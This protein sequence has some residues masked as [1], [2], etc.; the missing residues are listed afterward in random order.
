MTIDEKIEK[1]I[2]PLVEMYSKIESDLLCE[3]ASHFLIGEEFENADYYRIKKLEEMGA[4]NQNTIKYLSKITGA[5]EDKIRGCLQDIGIATIDTPE[6]S[7]LY[8]N[9]TINVDPKKLL[10]SMPIQAIID[11][12]YNEISNHFIELSS[13]IKNATR[14]AYLKVVEESYLKV[15]M[16]THSYDEAIRKAIDDLSNDGISVMK[17][18]TKDEDGNVIG[19]RSYD[20]EGVVRRDA[21]TAARQLSGNLNNQL[22]E[23]TQ[24][25]YVK[26][27]EHLD[28]RDTHF[29]WQGTIVKTEDWKSIADYGDIAGIYGINCRHYVEPYFGDNKG[30][31]EKK[32]TQEEC[33]KAYLLS[34]KQ[35]YLERGVRSW[36]RKAKMF[37]ASNDIYSYKKAVLKT[38][39]WQNKLDN[40]NDYA[41]TRRD[42]SREYV[43][44]YKDAT[45]NIIPPK[46]VVDK[47]EKINIKA[48]DSL[49]KI[50]TNL[51][52]RN[53]NQ[54]KKLTD[55]YKLKDYYKSQ[56]AIYL[57][58]DTS[59][60]IGAIGYNEEMTELS[61][62]SSYQY[63]YDKDYLTN[64]VKEH[65]ETGYYMPCKE[66]NYDIYAMTHE[67]GHTLEMKIFKDKYPKG[68]NMKYYHFCSNVKNDIINIALEKNPNL[69]LRIA[70]SNYGHDIKTQEFFAEAFANMELGKPNEIGKAMK[71]YLKREGI[72]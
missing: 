63:F 62:N 64:K 35:R 52:Q 32:Y 59:G 46:S 6:L 61:I 20:I 7:K 65:V 26:Y 68:N 10:N 31:E 23:E 27:S 58:P 8:K 70:I 39:E 51:L 57:S 11:N 4:F 47:L 34:Q 38:H 67:F 25:Q 41:N 45:V 13:K 19:I 50:P 37:H 60:F 15:S 3:I 72:L 30:N 2:E 53:V 49:G 5:T 66:S 56:N 48:D 40:F 21:L 44:G 9:G 12:A 55:K 69:D 36:K 24:C 43:N 1:A 29:P 18:E 28:C 22:I 54:Y 33:H 42:F 71:E 17:Y 14:E 16:G